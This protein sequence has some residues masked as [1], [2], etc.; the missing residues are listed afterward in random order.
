MVGGPVLVPVALSDPN[1][2]FSCSLS[3]RSCVWL[4]STSVWL[5]VQFF[6]RV[7]AK[8]R[9]LVSP[10]VFRH[11]AEQLAH[12]AFLS[13]WQVSVVLFLN[14]CDILAEKIKNDDMHIYFTD[15]TGMST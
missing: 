14:K 15:Y 12:R 8:G 3:A 13:T 5:C 11:V 1:S 10:G 7:S 4:N 6:G 2:H 9:R